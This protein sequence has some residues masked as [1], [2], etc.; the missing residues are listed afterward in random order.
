MRLG[1]KI[2][3]DST[4]DVIGNERYWGNSRDLISIMSCLID[5]GSKVTILR[6]CLT[7][8]IRP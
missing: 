4:G 3:R 1:H 7:E 2:Y 5:T 8:V 6:L